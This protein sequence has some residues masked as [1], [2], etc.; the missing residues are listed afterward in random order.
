MSYSVWETYNGTKEHKNCIIAETLEAIDDVIL[1][2]ISNYFLKFTE[3][4]IRQHGECKNNWYEYVEY[5]TTNRLRIVLQKSDFSREA[6]AYINGNQGDYVVMA[7]GNY[8]LRKS[9][10]ECGSE[11]VRREAADIIFN[12]PELFVD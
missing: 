12:L 9:I 5:G 1:F 8:K 11:L 7:D 2:R 4:Y 6:A 10:L 3:E